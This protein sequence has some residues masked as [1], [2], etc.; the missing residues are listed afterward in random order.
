MKTS[1]DQRLPESASGAYYVDERC[2]DCAVCVEIAPS[3]L[4]LSSEYRS[5]VKKQPETDSEIQAT[6]EAIKNCCVDAI[7]SDGP[8]RP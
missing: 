5:Y 1:Y 7:R 4:A 3:I 2:L 8:F 6:L